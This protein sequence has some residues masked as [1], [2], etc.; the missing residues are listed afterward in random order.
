M[1]HIVNAL[2]VRRMTVLMARRSPQ[3]KAYPGLWSFPGGHV[4]QGETLDAALSRELR[5][6]VGV[7]PIKYE[8][9]GSIAD[10]NATPNDPVNYYMYVVTE[11]RGGEPVVVDEEHS[12]LRWLDPAEAIA[13]ADLA[14]EAYRPL[15]QQVD[16][17]VR[18]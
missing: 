5:E 8:F 10:P 13:L 2:L 14:L 4:E 3:R 12:E 7:T 17:L 16:R 15:L 6:E 18:R 9:L 11:W 1:R